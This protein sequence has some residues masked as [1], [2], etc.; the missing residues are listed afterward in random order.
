MI[1]KK[2]LFESRLIGIWVSVLVFTPIFYPFAVPGALAQRQCEKE[3][4]EAENKYYRGRFLEAAAVMEQC[5][6]KSDLHKDEKKQA[7]E[8][9]AQIHFANND[10]AQA[11]N[12]IRRLLEVAPNYDPSAIEGASSLF[13]NLVNETKLAMKLSKTGGRKW[14]WLG[15]AGLVVG[16]TVA[17][18]L[19]EPPDQK[20]FVLPPGRP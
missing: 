9:L 12:A 18:V 8:L 14:L 17:I 15:G 1:M 3:L 16:I 5:L 6:K 20:G 4:E 11:K 7:Y 2:S 10:T 19:M 13:I